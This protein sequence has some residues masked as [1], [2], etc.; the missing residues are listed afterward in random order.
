M[1]QRKQTLFL[2]LSF[3][4]VVACFFLQVITIVNGILLLSAVLSL[5][6]VFL[7]KRR[8]QQALLCVFNM[9]I[10]VLWYLLFAINNQ[11]PDSVMSLGW[12]VLLPAIGIIMLF[13]ARQGIIADEKLV[14]SLDRIR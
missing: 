10:L 14:R 7:Y 4:L 1:I 3:M 6:A 12:P 8:K 13:L 11:N 9:L 2:L 5:V